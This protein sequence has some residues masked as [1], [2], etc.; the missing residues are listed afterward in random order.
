MYGNVMGD[1]TS[2]P[3]PQ[4][5]PQYRHDDIR[6]VNSRSNS[7]ADTLDGRYNPAFTPDGYPRVSNF[8]RVGDVHPVCV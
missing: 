5:Q 8:E 7:P 6:F 4:P 1:M 2:V 3:L